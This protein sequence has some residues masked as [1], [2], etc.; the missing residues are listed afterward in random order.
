MKKNLVVV[1][2]GLIILGFGIFQIS[3]Y[4]QK[5]N[6]KEK[7]SATIYKIEKKKEEYSEY[8]RSDHREHTK[9]YYIYNV[10]YKYEHQG[11]T[12]TGITQYYNL[13]WRENTKI[14]IYYDSATDSTDIYVIPYFWYYAS[15]I[16]IMLCVINVL[17]YQK[18]YNIKNLVQ[19]RTRSYSSTY[20]ITKF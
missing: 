15:I 18:N 8:D 6:N 3:Q 13:F 17:A 1:F 7:I 2:I 12:K 9:Y 20:Y 4:N 19:G 16:G 11:E 14:T 5:Y 10:Q